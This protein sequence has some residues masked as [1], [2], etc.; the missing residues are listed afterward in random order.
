M[1]ILYKRVRGQES[2][3]STATPHA[4]T[5]VT[6]GGGKIGNSSS[7]GGKR[8]FTNPTD[9]G[10]TSTNINRGDNDWERLSDGDS[11]RGI[12]AD[13]QKGGIRADYTFAVELDSYSTRD[14]R[15]EPKHIP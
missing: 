2:Q 12:L 13:G 5:L 7:K 15:P 6:I 14:L 9:R 4:N 3:A 11:D 10:V 1:R 8:A